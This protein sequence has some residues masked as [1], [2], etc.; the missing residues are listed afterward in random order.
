M[1]RIACLLL[2]LLLPVLNLWLLIGSIHGAGF[3]GLTLLMHAG[4]AAAEILLAW[5]LIPALQR[6]P[7]RLTLAL[8]LTAAAFLP[9]LGVPCFSLAAWLGVR[10]RRPQ[11][12]PP[13]RVLP[14]PVFTT[15]N[16]STISYGM[17]GVR[18]RLADPA[19]HPEARL[20]ALLT[21]K[22]MPTRHASELLRDLLDD[23]EEDLRL[24]AYGMLEHEEKRLDSQINAALERYRNGE[25]S[26]AR[27]LAFLYW[28]LIYHDLAQ[29]DVRAF[30]LG[31]VERY[32]AEAQEIQPRE[33]DLWMLR[34]KFA[35][36]NRQL[37]EAREA[38]ETASIL[39]YPHV[40]LI[41]YL[42]ELAFARRDF[43]AMR[44][45]FPSLNPLHVNDTLQPVVRYWSPR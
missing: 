10:S 1:K 5:W 34:G 12:E 13:F 15:R 6:R 40:K 4:I 44:A 25:L 8:L 28:E 32:L 39:G 18:M 43:A 26:A 45:L 31:E 36:G 17:G 3:T 27:T 2:W 24:L 41:P 23:P 22:S 14:A 29:G 19:T 42:A 7:R 37:A 9:G 35:L 21:L 38:F 33:P 11:A 20:S 30:A 16:R